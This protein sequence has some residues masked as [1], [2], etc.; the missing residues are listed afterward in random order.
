MTLDDFIA[1]WRPTSKIVGLDRQPDGS[2]KYT[3]TLEIE[4]YGA[5]G[6]Q[7]VYHF[8]PGTGFSFTEVL[9]SFAW[10]LALYYPDMP[11]YEFAEETGIAVNDPDLA[12]QY[13][14]MMAYIETAERGLGKACCDDLSEVR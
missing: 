2:C 5:P 12:R 10:D 8:P 13:R 11:I 6:L 9:L 3:Y 7:G 4:D 14:V 1:K